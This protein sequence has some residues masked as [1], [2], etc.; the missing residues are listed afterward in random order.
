[1]RRGVARRGVGAV[2]EE[3]HPEDDD[4]NFKVTASQQ[5]RIWSEFIDS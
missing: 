1:M 3:M 5:L 2:G 4:D